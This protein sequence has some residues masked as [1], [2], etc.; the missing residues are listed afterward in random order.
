[1]KFDPI[2]NEADIQF[3]PCATSNVKEFRC[4]LGG[5]RPLNE[6]GYIY[7]AVFIAGNYARY[8]PDRWVFDVENSTPL[9]LAIEELLTIAEKR[10]PWLTLSELSRSY[11]VFDK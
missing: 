2:N 5:P 8:Y 6:F 3:P 9:A 11:H 10:V 1:L 4:W 7:A